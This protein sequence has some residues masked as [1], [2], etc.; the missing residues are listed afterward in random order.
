MA[1][2]IRSADPRHPDARETPVARSD[3]RTPDQIAL[4][5]REPGRPP[6]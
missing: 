5:N 6:L 4:F 3:T 1:M 2:E